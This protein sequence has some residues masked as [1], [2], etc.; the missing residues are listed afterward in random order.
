MIHERG[1]SIS[2]RN[3]LAAVALATG[4]LVIGGALVVI[5]LALLAGIMVAG[6]VVGTGV[7]AYRRLRGN[8]SKGRTALGTRRHLDPRLEVFPPDQ[9]RE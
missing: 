8:S 5:G 2:T 7:A 6:A 3:K 4:A 1:Y 9:P